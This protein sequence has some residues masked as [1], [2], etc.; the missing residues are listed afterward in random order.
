MLNQDPRI[1]AAV[2]FGRG[3]FQPGVLID[4]RNEYK[5]DPIDEQKLEAFRNLVWYS[6]FN[7][8]HSTHG[9]YS[10]YHNV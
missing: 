10:H 2:I 6:L 1:Q 9:Q 7:V 5:F 4:P 3:K 8:L